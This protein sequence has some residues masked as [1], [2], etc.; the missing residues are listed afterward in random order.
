MTLDDE[1]R[2]RLAALPTANIGDAMDRLNVLES[3]IKPVWTG[4]R[5]V[6]PAYCV[7]TAPGD[8]RAL[9]DALGLAEPG[10]VIV[11]SGGGYTDRALMG[12]LMAGRAIARGIAGVVIDGAIRD[13][14]DI[15]ELKL[16]VYAKAVTPAGPYRNGPGRQQVPVAVGN[17]AVSP[18]D[19]VV[20]DDDGVVVIP[21]QE[22][23]EVLE[24]AERK[25]EA[26]M[27]QRQEIG[28]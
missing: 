2:A 8:N 9:H 4:A 19:I 7:L 1:I 11:L 28:V 15:A 17:V 5:V 24:R 20:G 10:E 23:D 18:G 21:R 25:H 13:A 3:R 12:E 6:G 26:E 27:L 16:P 22:L 14:G